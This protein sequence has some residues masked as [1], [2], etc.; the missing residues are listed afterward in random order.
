VKSTVRIKPNA[1][2]TTLLSRKAVVQI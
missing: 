1:K 2:S